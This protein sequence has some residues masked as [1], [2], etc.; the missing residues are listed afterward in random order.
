M[1]LLLY[2]SLLMAVVLLAFVRGR[3]DEQMA[4][5]TCVVGTALTV[6]VSH[7]LQ[8]RFTRFDAAAFGIDVL[9]LAA[10]LF[11]ALRS[12]R[13]WPL[14]VSGLQL[15]ATT[16]HLLKILDPGLMQFVFA[17]A[18]AFWS[19]PILLFIGVGAWRTRTI[20]RWRALTPLPATG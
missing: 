9:V 15:V 3:R 12:D 4:A 13:F 7:I 18:L 10:F 6:A 19:Y 17:A 1:R 20:E 2:Y 11:I 14:W 16:V 5:L 8:D